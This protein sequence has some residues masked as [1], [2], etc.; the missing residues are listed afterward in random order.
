MITQIIISLV[1]LA[2]AYVIGCIYYINGCK[3]GY[4]AGFFD[5]IDYTQN[6]IT[7]AIKKGTVTLDGKPVRTVENGELKIPE[8]PP[9][10]KG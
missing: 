7:E 10:A 8:I 9:E 3:R 1:I 5:G 4:E 6:A 2:L